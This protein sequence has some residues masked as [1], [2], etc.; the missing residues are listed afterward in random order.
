VQKVDLSE[1]AEQDVVPQALDGVPT[2][3]LETGPFVAFSPTPRD[4]W[5][6]VIPP[7]ASLA[8]HRVTAGTFGCLVRRGD[9]IFILSNNHVLADVNRGRVG[10]AILQPSPSDMGTRDDRVATLAE[11]VPLDFGQSP[12]ECPLATWSA[13]L[14]NVVAGAFGSTHRLQAVK[15]TAGVNRV[16]AALARP[17]SPGL[18]SNAI[19]GIGAPIGVGTGELGMAIQKTGRTTGYTEGLITQFDA[20]IRVDYH[21]PVAVFEGQFVASPMSQPGDSGSAVLDRENRV[22]GLLFAGSDQA[23]LINPV[24][25]VLTM[26]DVELVV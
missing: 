1:L 11:F 26:L 10:D 25:D 21:G 19:L 16:D 14:L 2:D 3:V 13:R 15:Q 4:R 6:P 24:G 17:H 8:H 20:T 9:D 18:V 5:R 23:T 12:P 7:G 22:V